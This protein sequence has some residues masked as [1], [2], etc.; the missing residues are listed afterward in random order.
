MAAPVS[1]AITPLFDLISSLICS[2]SRLTLNSLV[3]GSIVG[4]Y[5]RYTVGQDVLL[6]FQPQLLPIHRQQNYRY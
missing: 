4:F 5:R 2:G 1:D 3:C 6:P